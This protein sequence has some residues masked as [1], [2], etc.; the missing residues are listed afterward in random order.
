MISNLGYRGPLK[1]YIGIS[2]SGLV[3]FD[4]RN[5]WANQNIIIIT[6]IPIL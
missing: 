6:E 2:V 5:H 1:V 3:K 4:L